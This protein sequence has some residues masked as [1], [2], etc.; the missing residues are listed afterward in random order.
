MYAPQWIDIIQEYLGWKGLKSGCYYFMA[1]MNERFDEQKQAMIAKYTPLS[2]E[3]LQDGAFDIDWFKE[4][5]ALLG[6]KNFSL[7]YKAAKYISDGQK[8][9]RARKYADA[10]SGKVTLEQ[11]R[12][13]IGAKRNK[14]LLMSYGLV[15]F[16][17]EQKK[18]MVG[19][20]QFIQNYAKDAKKYGAQRR[21]SETK[22]ARIGLVNLSVHAGFSDVT[23]LTL[24]M[25]TELIQ[26]LT[27][28]MEWTPVEDVEVRLEISQEGRSGILCRK[29]GKLL[30]SVP[31]RLGKKPYILEVKDAHKKLKDQ[32]VRAKKMMEESM[33]SGEW[34]TAA[35]VGGLFKNPVVKAI[36]SPLV[37]ACGDKMGFAEEA[38]GL[39][40]RTWAGESLPLGAD[41]RL[42]IAHPLDL[43]KAGMWHE[44]QKY[45][46]EHQLRQPFKQVFRELYV[47][48]PEELGL[49]YSRM[50]AGNQ[51]QPQ[52]TVGALKSRRWV[53]DYEEGL[54]KIFY[55]E[56]IIARIY[57]MA[58]WFSPSDV[59]APTLEWVE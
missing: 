58:D 9:S 17:R 51:I 33:E 26:E 19:R 16:G 11:L 31:S 48:M 1:H 37:F 47:K 14:D 7:L 41:D 40:L 18:D 57:A 15:P 59:E 34:F 10:A 53:A 8:H 27:P 43:Y 4:C 23:R 21:A 30:K 12:A 54:Q 6:E 3:E 36:L 45:L 52:K 49:R 20:Y 32:Y 28:Y 55:K 38:A 39:R 42:R 25:E 24:N 22:T 5:Y 35:E 29:N 50:F 56:N 44:Y 2:M 13:E 46:F